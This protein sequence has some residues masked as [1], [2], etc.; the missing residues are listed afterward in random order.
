MKQTRR[1]FLKATGAT[2]VAGVLG[3]GSALAQNNS[4]TFF[5][6]GSLEFDPGTEENISR[7]EDETGITVNVNE[8]PW[9]NLKTTLITQW[10]NQ[11][12]EADAF[13]GPTW[14]LG[15]FVAADWVEPLDLGDDHMGKF[16]DS[17]RNLVTFDGQTYM[18]PQIGKWGAYVYDAQYLSDQGVDSPPSTWDEVIE[19]GEQLSSDDKSGFGFTWANKDVFTFK[20]FLY[21]AGGQLFNENNE[22]QFTSDAAV[23]VFQDLINPLRERGVIPQGLQSMGEGGVGDAFIGGQFATV[24]SWTPLGARALGEDGWGA[25]RLGVARPPEGSESDATFQDTNGVSVSAFSQ[26]KEAAKQFA[27]FMSTTESCKTD[28]LVEG[29]PA[30]VPEVYEDSE[31]REKYPS[32]WLDV[33]KYNLQNAKSEIY[34]AQPQVDDMLSNQI[35][36]ALLGEKEPQEALQQAQEEVTSLYENLGIL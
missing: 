30:A 21:Q 35:T 14:W 15:D 8:V 33:N 2:G 7:F 5:N 18:A 4:I 32:K 17:L 25:E 24:E 34:R 28:M 20:Q 11:S 29:N 19:V 10:R 31:I 26:N 12:S 3:S 27:R 16:P 13:N 36:P 9:Q 6:A 23:S 22:P 1:R